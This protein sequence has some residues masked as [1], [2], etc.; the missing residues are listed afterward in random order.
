MV[1]NE[2]EAKSLH[3]QLKAIT[4]TAKSSCNSLMAGEKG[5]PVVASA[6]LDFFTFSSHHTHTH[7]LGPINVAICS[8][9]NL[10]D[11]MW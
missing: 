1:A 9:V 2:I 5:K 11:I 10:N 7:I 6:T 4:T 8:V 3:Q